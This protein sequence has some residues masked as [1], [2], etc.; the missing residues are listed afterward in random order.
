MDL[1]RLSLNTATVRVQWG[2]EEC[3]QACLKYQIPAL[4]PW[5]NTIQKVGL[6]KARKII[7][8]SGLKVSSLCRG[9][10]F[11]QKTKNLFQEN[12]E[13]N[14]RA[15][16][17]ANAINAECLVLVVGGLAEGSKNIELAREQVIKGISL[18]LD[19]AKKNQMP[20]GIE[21]LHPMYAADRACVN[22]V[23]QALDICSKFCDDYLGVVLDVYHI[24]WDPFLKEAI[25]K[26]KGKILGYHVCD[27]HRETND[28]LLDRGMMG[29]GVIDIK[30][31]SSWIEKADYQGLVE[32]EIFSKNI[33]WKKDA[34]EV[35]KVMKDR[36]LKYV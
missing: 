33:W 1:S 12:I 23:R 28:L 6:K 36:F 29:D 14:F 11:P 16:D 5:R 31:I 15:I 7:I 18:I 4:A 3:V 30:Q 19:Y 27:W 21:P 25:K 2:L 20:L 17:E 26:A 9:G 10:M 22:T 34:G 24:W 32:V 35:I 13:D 8:D